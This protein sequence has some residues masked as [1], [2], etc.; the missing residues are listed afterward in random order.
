MSVKDLKNVHLIDKRREFRLGE[1]EEGNKTHGKVT[2]IQLER[3]RGTNIKG[4]LIKVEFESGMV[5][6]FRTRYYQYR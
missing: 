3:S 6:T 2:R 1:V 5:Q 4:D